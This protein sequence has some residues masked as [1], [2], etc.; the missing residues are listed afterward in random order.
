MKIGLRHTFKNIFS[1]FIDGLLYKLGKRA[2]YEE[3]RSGSKTLIKEI[4]DDGILDKATILL[5]PTAWSDARLHS[6]KTYT[7]TNL[8]TNGDFATDSDWTKGTGW[9]ISGGSAN[10]NN[11]SGSTQDLK[12]EN[13]ILN[14]GGKTVKIEFTVS[15]YSGSAS[16]I[17]TLEGT[18]GN[19]FTGINANGTY[20]AYASIASS[21]NSIDLLFKA[22]NGWIGSID[23]ISVKDVSSDFDFERDSSATRVDED[24][25]IQDMQSLVEPE[26][27]E[28]GDFSELGSELTDNSGLDATWLGWNLN[29]ADI[30]GGIISCTAVATGLGVYC[31]YDNNLLTTTMPT[32]SWFKITCQAKVSSGHSFAVHTQMH[33]SGITDSSTITSTA[34]VDVEL[35]A[36]KDTGSDYFNI[37]SMSDI[38]MTAYI[39]NISVK[40]LDPDDDWSVANSTTGIEENKAVITSDGS[41]AKITTQISGTSGDVVKVTF[42]ISDE[43][44][45]GL[46]YVR[47]D[48]TDIQASGS[49]VSGDTTVY[50]TLV[51]SGTLDLVFMTY[52][53]ATASF[54]LKDVSVKDVTFSEDVD[55]PRIDY[56]GGVGHI[57][58]EPASTNLVT[59]SED[60]SEWSLNS[61]LTLSLNSAT[62]PDGNV[63]AD[64]VSYVGSVGTPAGKNMQM[65]I[66]VGGGTANKD[67][68]NSIY[69]KGTGEFRI[70]NTHG[71]VV[72]SYTSDLT[73]TSDWV[74]YDLSVS[75]SSS[76]GSGD[77]IVGILAASTDAAFN[78]D[79]WGAQLEELSY[80]TSYIPTHTGVAVTRDAET[81][82]GSGNDTLINST[83][84]VLYCEIAALSDDL[85]YREI[86]LSDGTSTN[87]VEIRY[88][89][90]SNRIQALIRNGSYL[91]LQYDV[92]SI[93]DFNKVAFKWKTEDFALWVNG[94]EVATDA[95]AFVTSGLNRLAFDQGTSGNTFYGN[96]K[97]LAVFDEALSDV[98]LAALTS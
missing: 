98:E 97:C 63:S 27:V 22:S 11:T 34:W 86:S 9:T 80:A 24:G 35:Y 49:W 78:L 26:L 45:T 17:V 8:V 30:N 79:I 29:T 38:G 28:N 31:T 43:V 73:A 85:T 19:D 93:V 16:M 50:Y 15:N 18:G 2:T 77:Q 72:D 88:T 58:L 91:A 71:G 69:I 6:V 68:T 66:S 75:N 37:R 60:F 95:T 10:C 48:G 1:D 59:Y 7:G 23:N 54:T 39:K 46:A 82:D 96:T 57:L 83:E 62:S 44:S 3:N 40:Q 5:T 47:I 89:T 52:S 74:R 42:N 87:R 14:L 81:L 32:A 90:N 12:T 64:N 4:S 61:N 41:N 65:T 56:T 13:R 25:L 92:S 21:S 94:V 76:V 36:Y 70:K 67:F 51:S 84:G 20:N 33:N 55:L 53:T